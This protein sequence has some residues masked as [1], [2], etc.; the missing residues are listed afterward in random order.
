MTRKREKNSYDRFLQQRLGNYYYKR[1]VPAEVADADDRA[2]HVRIALKTDDV[3]I[4]RAKRDALEIADNEFWASLLSGSNAAIA[5]R[6]YSAAVKRAQAYGF[7][8][9]PVADLARDASRADIVDRFELINERTQPAVETA[10]LGGVSR[11]NAKV[12]EAFKT[13]L[14]QIVPDEHMGK[15]AF[16]KYQW[17]KVKQRAVNNFVELIGDKAMTEIT[18]DDARELYDHWMKRIAPKSG[19]ATHSP[20]SGNRDVG[21]MRVLYKAYFEY[22]GD[23]E[24]KNPFDGLSFSEKRKKTR[25]PF[26][27][28]WITDTILKPGSLST[29]NSEGRGVVLALI[30][31]GARPSE[32]CNLTPDAICLEA[33]IPHLKIKPRE[34]PDDPREVKTDSSIRE[35][36]LVGV[37]LEVFKQHPNGFPRY[38]NKENHMS[39]ALNKYFNARALFPSPDHKIYSFRH[40]FEDRMKDANLHDDLRRLLM[41]HAIDRPTYGSGGSLEWKRDEML[42]IALPFDASIV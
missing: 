23:H 14:E 29:M 7:S 28:E 31:T 25:P 27:L 41:G 22:M 18:R 32:L 36:P 9:K 33:A 5:Q 38:R 4:A 42:K 19:R 8:Y 20:S 15:S 2:P 16:Q 26:P 1:R 37:A 13:Y 3:T 39:K 35:V 24:R 30:E 11:P 40:S 10:L 6:L 12:S 21:N 34:D 17:K